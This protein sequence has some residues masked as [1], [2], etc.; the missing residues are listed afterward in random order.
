MSHTIST[1][2]VSSAAIGYAKVVIVDYAA[3]GETFSN[4]ALEFN[5]GQILGVVLGT[6]HPSQNSLGT[7]LFPILNG[8]KVQLYRLVSGV[9]AEIPT[10]AALNATIDLVFGF[11]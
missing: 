10:T 9:P 8:N 6:V 2:I 7:A 5:V 11:Q 1:R 4:P 3:G